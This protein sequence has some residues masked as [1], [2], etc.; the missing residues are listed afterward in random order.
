M[1]DYILKGAMVPPPTEHNAICSECGS[2]N[3][4]GV[5]YKCACCENYNLCEGCE[6]N[7]KHSEHPM[8]K[9]RDPS[10][11]VTKISCEI[12]P[13]KEFSFME[14]AK[15]FLESYEAQEQMDVKKE[16]FE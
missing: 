4:T 11:V 9:I 15:E 10:Q 16:V 8:L 1:A 14:T 2:K 13:K 12:Q 5:L 7:G 3:I 6:A